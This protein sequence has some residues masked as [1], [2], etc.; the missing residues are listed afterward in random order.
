MSTKAL[1]TGGGGFLGKA[2]IK[3]LLD[4]G[5]DVCSFS[6]GDY[7][8]LRALGVEVVRGDIQDA[9]AVSAAVEGCDIVFHVAAKVGSWG[10]F[11]DFYGANVIGTQRILDACQE[12][13]VERLVYTSSPSVVFGGGDMKGVDESVPY[14]ETYKAFYP[15]TKAEAERRVRQAGEDGVVKTI[16][17]RPHLIWGPE[18]T[19]L[20]PRILERASSL[21]IIGEGDNLVDTIYIDNAADAHILAAD[22]LSE[23]PE[24]AG[25]VYFISQDEP[26][27]CWEMINDILRAGGKP[28]LTRKISLKAAYRIAGMMEFVYKLFGIRSEPRLTRFVVGEL[29]T[30][31]WFDI[32]AAKNDLGFVP[33]VSTEEGLKRLAEWLQTPS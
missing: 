18:D 7:P 25:R 8:E 10:K 24:L 21:R 26:V 31:H 32:S 2:I 1:V 16:T 6:R 17:I 23:K 27:N 12:H 3:R 11:E 22:A 29:A 13:Q 14:P 20:V 5:W 30:S 28:P 19:N 9:S 15:Q 4:R 33:K